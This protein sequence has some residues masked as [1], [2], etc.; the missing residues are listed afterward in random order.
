[1]IV[2]NG[3]RSAFSS[4][5]DRLVALAVLLIAL[6]A[7]RSSLS[8]RPFIVAATAVVGLAAAVG[9]GV[10]LM[11]GHRLDFHAEDGVLAEDALAGGARQYYILSIHALVCAVATLCALIGR[12][13]TAML[14]PIGYLVGA[15]ICHL[16]RRLATGGGARRRSPLLRAVRRL[17][18]RPLSG[19]VAA[20]PAVMS[21]LLLQSIGPGPLAAFIGM[22]SAV[23]AI[24]LTLPDHDVVRFMSASGYRAGRIIGL[25]ARSLLVFLV[26]TIPASL[27]LSDTLVAIVIFGVVLAAWLLM[28]A[29]ILAYRA[30]SKRAADTAVSVCVVFTGFTGYAIPMLLPFVVIAILWHLHRRSVPATWLLA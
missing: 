1:M 16:V 22:I 11:I 28:T 15:G 20:I 3:L 7:M 2:A 4:W 13:M 21:L 26:L 18:Q 10:A 25:H 29:R 27:I 5:P 14:A 23:A 12:P 9:A 24:L 17:L 30:Y 8:D 19:V 6:A